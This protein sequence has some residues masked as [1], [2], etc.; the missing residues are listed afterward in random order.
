LV[1]PW[2]IIGL[3]KMSLGEVIMLEL[4]NP[5]KP[6]KLHHKKMSQQGDKGGRKWE[7]Q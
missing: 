5:C 3:K 4:H 2:L 6:T 1:C 7:K